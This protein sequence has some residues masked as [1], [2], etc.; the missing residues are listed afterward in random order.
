M[1]CPN[2]P[3]EMWV[4]KVENDTIYYECKKCGATKEV[5]IEEL[6]QDE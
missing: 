5:S 4:S 6:S 1:Q 2:C 3:L